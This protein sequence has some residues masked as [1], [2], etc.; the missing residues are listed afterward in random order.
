M[1]FEDNGLSRTLTKKNKEVGT[2]VQGA[3][4]SCQIHWIPLLR[5]VSPSSMD[6][7]QKPNFKVVI[8]E[9]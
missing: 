9:S 3:R 5:Y 1:P 7:I 8:P 4:F 6:P 2:W